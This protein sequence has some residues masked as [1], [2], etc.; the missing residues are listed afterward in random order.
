MIPA[1]GFQKPIPK[2]AEALARK[3]YTSRFS[4]TAASMSGAAPCWARIR[5][6]QCTVV[7]VRTRGIAA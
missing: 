3:A 2:R 5:W 6:S 4:S 7:G 1:P